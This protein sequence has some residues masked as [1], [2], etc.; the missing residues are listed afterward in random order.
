MGDLADEAREGF[1]ADQEFSRLLI[2]PDFAKG[3]GSRTVTV[4]LLDASSV[5]G[6]F[7]SGLGGELLSWS[8]ASRGPAG[9]LLGSSHDDTDDDV[10]D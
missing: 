3:N 9:G 1:L 7:A 5:G 10:V 4:G 8:L 6:G 2:A